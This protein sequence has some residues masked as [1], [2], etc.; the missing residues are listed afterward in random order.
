MTNKQLNVSFDEE[1]RATIHQWSE[2]SGLS[3]AGIVRAMVR[4][5]IRRG[6][7]PT[8]TWT[9]PEQDQRGEGR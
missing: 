9:P 1:T 6:W 2:T 8:D 3:E 4:F 5:A 7:T